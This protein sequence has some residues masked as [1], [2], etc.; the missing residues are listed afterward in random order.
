MRVLYGC[1]PPAY[2]AH[3]GSAAI[4]ECLALVSDYH[5]MLVT[6]RHYRSIVEQVG[7]GLGSCV[8]VDFEA[9]WNVLHVE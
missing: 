1:V 4:L 9:A 7:G 2:L 3:S 5:E 8:V 6:E